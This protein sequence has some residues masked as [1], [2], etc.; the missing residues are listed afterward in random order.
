MSF[1]EKMRE[2]VVDPLTS[3]VGTVTGE[4]HNCL[5]GGCDPGVIFNKGVR[6]AASGVAS[7]F[8]GEARATVDHLFINYV[9]PL[10]DEIDIMLEDRIKQTGSVAEEVVERTA[11][12]LDTLKDELRTDIEALVANVDDRIK[13]NVRF[14]LERIAQTVTETIIAIRITI[15]DIDARLEARIKQLAQLVMQV[16]VTLDAIVQSAFDRLDQLERQLAKDLNE[17]WE[18]IDRTV[19]GAQAWL[20]LIRQRAVDF[21]AVGAGVVF[22]PQLKDCFDENNVPIQGG[23]SLARDEIYVLTRC[24]RLKD[25]ERQLEEGELQVESIVRNYGF[26]QQQAWDWLTMNRGVATQEEMYARDY[27]YFG[28]KAN[29]WMPFYTP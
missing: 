19:L 17:T 1:F 25:M 7:E 12:E 26:L 21:P 15:A 24:M 14:F 4:L 27:L 2:T 5:S 3:T 13:D 8:G 23:L 6:G 16:L 18:K 11:A 22:K 28:A 9:N 29:I 10:A 20:D